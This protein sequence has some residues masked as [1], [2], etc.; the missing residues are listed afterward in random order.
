MAKMT[1]TEA[2][3]ASS[4]DQVSLEAAVA[5]VT[6][7]LGPGADLWVVNVEGEKISVYGDYEQWSAV[8]T[9]KSRSGDNFKFS[10]WGSVTDRFGDWYHE[11]SGEGDAGFMASTAAWVLDCAG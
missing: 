2:R 7:A 8:V 5:A 4:V 6:N 1:L 9:V 10:A 11:S 3:G